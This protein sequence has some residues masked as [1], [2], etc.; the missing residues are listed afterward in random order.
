MKTQTI[1]GRY[2]GNMN[3]L[4]YLRSLEIARPRVVSDNVLIYDKIDFM[5][6]KKMELIN[7]LDRPIC[8]LCGS[9][10]TEMKNGYID[11]YSCGCTCDDLSD[12]LA[13][14]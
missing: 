9:T 8:P 13:Q 11:C 12:S 6:L 1:D 2:R 10:S 5:T 3:T 4:Q 14:Y 7:T